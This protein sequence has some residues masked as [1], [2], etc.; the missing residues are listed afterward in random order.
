MMLAAALAARPAAAQDAAPLG[1]ARLDWWR[2]ARFGMFV[3]WGLYSI[4]AGEWEGDAGHAEWI[5]T[6]ARI[7]DDRYAELAGQFDPT[8]FDAD[9]WVL[10]AKDAGMRYLVIT[11]KHHD[12]F[13]LFD[14]AHTDF[15]IMATPFARDIMA[16]LAEAGRR[17]GVRIGWYHSIMDW[18]HPDYLPRREWEQ[19][20]AA[21]ADFDRY[22]THLHAQVT[23]L[24]TNYGDVGVMWFD[25]EWED[26]W[27]TEHGRAL[28]DLCRRLQPDV[29]VN[30]RVDK[31]RAGM[32]GLTVD[33]E[34]LGD[35]GTP[36]QEVPPAGLPGVDWETCLT[37]ND[38]WGHVRADT[39]H[40]SVTEL[41]RTLVDVA[42]KGGNLLLNVG[43]DATGRIPP[44]SVERLRGVGAWMRVNGEAI[45]G[46]V[47]T[48]LRP[49]PWGRCTMRPGP[50]TRLY[51]HVFEWPEHGHFRVEG[52]ANTPLR[53]HVMGAHRRQLM[54]ARRGEGI[55]I[56]VPRAAPNAHCSV[57]VLDIEGEPVV[58][59]PAPPDDA[60]PGDAPPTTAPAD[61]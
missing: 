23:E 34:R 18:H 4:P 45:R 42:S 35:F 56:A 21:G 10:L 7:P 46:T 40:K 53:A 57:V 48:P 61:D 51:L 25:G 37:L 49:Q 59:E 5:R 14:S 12:G 11:T 15:D 30:N 1:D 44:E 2:E 36:E 20:P 33:P 38:H 28:Y 17:H 9:A 41:V 32:A 24:L 60:P 39:N 19:R 47:A 43:P 52:L 16:E 29:I 50:R 31:G 26:T 27:N 6:T 55:E 8:A 13:C 54:V 58:P 3:H 22:V